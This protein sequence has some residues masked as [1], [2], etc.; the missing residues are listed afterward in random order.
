MMEQKT[1]NWLEHEDKVYEAFGN[2]LTEL[3]N[4][5]K[6]DDKKALKDDEL[7]KRIGIELRNRTG[8]SKRLIA[9][10]LEIDR[11]RVRKLLSIAPSP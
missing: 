1:Y 4:K 10:K 5:Y 9:Q 7:L 2:V 8:A 11:E 6:I 3:V